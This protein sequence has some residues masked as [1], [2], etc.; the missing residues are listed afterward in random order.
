M[1]Q[2]GLSSS[3]TFS[4][5]ATDWRQILFPNLTDVEFADQYSQTITFTLLL[6]RVEGVS[7][8]GRSV[9]EIARLRGK[10]HSLM[11]RALAVLT[12]QPDIR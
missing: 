3:Q 11:S 2:S 10:K 9:G 8:Q 5:L 4:G 12:D 1:E 7:C 6:A